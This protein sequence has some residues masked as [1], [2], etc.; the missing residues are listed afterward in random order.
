[1]LKVEVPGIDREDLDISSTRD[2]VV[3]RGERRYEDPQEN[4]N[5]YVS[6]FS[7]S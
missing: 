6:E 7:Y 2:V 5:R 1:M 3:I 4:N